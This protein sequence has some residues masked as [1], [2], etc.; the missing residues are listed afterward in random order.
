MKKI[1]SLKHTTQKQLSLYRIN[2]DTKRVIIE[3]SLQTYMEYFHEWDNAVFRK[4]DVHPEL[5]EF[6]D[7]CSEDIP[8]HKQIE[9]EFCIKN[10]AEDLEKER[11]IEASF[12]NFYKAQNRLIT[13]A[14]RKLLHKAIILFAVSC[15][16]IALHLI[17][18][19]STN[20]HVFFRLIKEGVLIGGWV[21]MWEGFHTAFMHIW[22]PLRRRR[23]INRFLNADI[24][25]RTIA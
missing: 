24:R 10:R 7:L 6:L 11:L 25:F 14:V 22:D 23:I 16:F 19:N 20:T 21:F 8:L 9:I 17:L 12:R 5:A 15:L 2:P 4:R 18:S 3:I 1:P 13:L